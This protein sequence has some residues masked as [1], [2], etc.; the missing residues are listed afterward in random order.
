ML[1]KLLSLD[2]LGEPF[3]SLIEN[4][5]NN[6]DTLCYGLS[7]TARHQIAGFLHSKVLYVTNNKVEADEAMNSFKA[8]TNNNVS[9]LTPKADL[10][11][12]ATSFSREL[13]FSRMCE[14]NQISENQPQVIVTTVEAIS[15]LFP[16][17]TRFDNLRTT[18]KIN[19]EISP[20]EISE[21]LVECGFERA[22]LIEGAGQFA[23]R[24]DILDIFEPSGRAVR[25]DFFGDTIE[26]IKEIDSETMKSS[27]NIDSINIFPIFETIIEDI[28]RKNLIKKYEK[29]KPNIKTKELEERWLSHNDLVMN[30]IENARTTTLS[31]LLPLLKEKST[32]FDYLDSETTIVFDDFNKC[33]DIIKSHELEHKSRYTAL[34]ES[35]ELLKTQLNQMFTR[36]SIQKQLSE[37]TK[38]NLVELLTQD[39]GFNPKS[40][41]EF[42][43]TKISSYQHDNDI[44]KNDI[45]NW[46]KF[47]YKVVICGKDKDTAR[48]FASQIIA[49]GIPTKYIEDTNSEINGSVIV[50]IFIEHGYILHNEKI[51][52]IGSYDVLKRSNLRIN[53]KRKKGDAFVSCEIGDYVVHDIHGIGLLKAVKTVK[54]GDII[55]DYAIVEYRGGDILY[56]PA[57]Q[58]DML[59]KFSGSEKT[60][61]LSKMGGKEFSNI[62][63]KVRSSIREMAFDLRELYKNRENAKGHIYPKDSAFQAEFEDNFDFE[64]TRDQLISTN[65]IKDDMTSE[66]VMDRLL[67]GDVGYGKTEVA[68]R[69]CFKAIE[70]GKQICFLAPTTILSYQHYKTALKRFEG[71]GIRLDY[72]NRFKTKMEQIETIRRLKEGKIDMIFGTHRL[73]SKD[74]SFADL[75]LLILDEE[76]RFGVEHKEKIKTLKSNID[77]LSMSA[78]PIPRTL[79]MSLSGIRDISTIETPPSK[80]LPVQ[81]I[82]TEQSNAIIADSIRKE[83]ARSGQVFVLYNR[84]SSIYSYTDSLKKLLPKV[85]FIVAHGQMD[86]VELEKSIENF[87]MGKADVLVSTTIIENG[88]DI[89]RANTMLV[90]DSDRLGLSQLYQLKGRVGRSDKLAYIYYLYKENKVL[91]ETARK[92]LDAIQEFTEFGSGFKIAMRDLEIRGSGNIL[93]REQSGH[94]EKVGYD[95]YC[96]LLRE[97]VNELDG[98]VVK[99][100]PTDMDVDITAYI[101]EDY[102]TSSTAR[103]EEYRTISSIKTFD[104]I[105][106][107][108]NS[109]EDIYGKVPR[110]VKAL[111]RIALV[112]HLATKLFAKQIIIRENRVEIILSVESLKN[113]DLHDVLSKCKRK[114]NLIVGDEITIKFFEKRTYSG[115]RTVF[116]FLCA[117]FL[118]K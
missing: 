22:E 15:Q 68:F 61:R 3:H 99:E 112:R 100:T 63:E 95:M 70:S 11:V 55:R 5:N 37:F 81:V 90:V 46:L 78:T 64:P 73:L 13:L 48:N 82:V 93:G 77:V 69:A 24:G 89:P 86:A 19:D 71:F 38:L 33:N 23:I 14:I 107:I 51:V 52:I 65:E 6:I 62:K 2:K 117:V 25:I 54:T 12:S 17:K 30:N 88:I 94:M 83:L 104:D 4:V 113:N 87:V 79:H 50:P 7:S 116:N 103:I 9:Y 97:A 59:V 84:V 34:F 36:T 118:E 40:L 60:P 115:L 56:V 75:G 106:E 110:E 49:E 18:I 105:Q 1:D 67:V 31:E 41:L 45:K 29:A 85:K 44:L 32:I 58:M 28:E 42:K 57:A 8:F 20:Y 26:R 39:K 108:L 109:L 92:R 35:G 72:I 43:T 101:P 16:P 21:K 66:K 76:Q 111:A 91:S 114:A 80:R 27:E 47:G 102:I 98:K 96:K 74:V 10:L 53:S